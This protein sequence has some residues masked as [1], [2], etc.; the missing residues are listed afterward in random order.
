MKNVIE[1][2]FNITEAKKQAMVE[3]KRVHDNGT[4]EEKQTILKFVEKINQLNIDEITNICIELQ[5]AM[6]YKD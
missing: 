6:K 5:S 4:E 3:L 2:L 1:S